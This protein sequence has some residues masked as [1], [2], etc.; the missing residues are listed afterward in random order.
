MT[1]STE[2]R[3]WLSVDDL[4]AWIGVPVKTIYAWRHR[5]VGPRAATLGRHLKFRRSD[6]EA[7]IAEQ[8]DDRRAS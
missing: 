7:W 4:A 3:E 2:A 1:N 8:Y 6:V 5:G